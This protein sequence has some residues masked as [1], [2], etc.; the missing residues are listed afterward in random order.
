MKTFYDKEFINSWTVGFEGLKKLVQTFLRNM[1]KKVTW[2]PADKI[3][4]A[5]RLFATVKPAQIV[6]TAN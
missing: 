2:V 5:A 1:L 6:T 3:R 4:K